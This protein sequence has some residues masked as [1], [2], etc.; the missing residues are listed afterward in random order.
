MINTFRHINRL[1]S[2]YFH[3]P[4]VLWK[5]ISQSA[6]SMFQHDPRFLPYPVES[7]SIEN[8]CPIFSTHNGNPRSCY[9]CLPEQATLSDKSF[10]RR[11]SFSSFCKVISRTVFCSLTSAFDW[12]LTFIYAKAYTLEYNTKA[13]TWFNGQVSRT[14]V[15]NGQC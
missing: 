15:W 11:V 2:K 5:V 6:I 14:G 3:I 4:L 13:P 1:L 9:S 12:N 7:I 8:P 10:T